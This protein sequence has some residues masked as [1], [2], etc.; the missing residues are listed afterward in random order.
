MDRNI[1]MRIA[2]L[3]A[4]LAAASAL[5]ACSA[6]ANTNDARDAAQ[7]SGGTADARTY[8]LA[9]FTGVSLMGSDNVVVQQ[10]GRFAVSASGDPAALD[11]LYLRVR[12][13]KLE[14][15]RRSDGDLVRSKLTVRV[16]MPMLELASV[17]GSGMID[18]QQLGG[19]RARISVAGSGDV[20]VA[21]VA[22]DA[23]DISVAGSGGVHAA[24]RADN[25]RFSVAG[26][27]DV[28][29]PNLELTTSAVS[30]GGS[31]SVHARVTG[32]ASVNIAGSGNATLTGG[33]QCTV[34]SVGS[35][36]AN[37]S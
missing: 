17:A 25:G 30:I 9:G 15:R 23:I 3:V 19:E 20:R 22:A 37:C 7:P 31:G 16:T 18:A 28:D 12:D 1:Y 26:S 34:R 33:A 11:Q 5:G 27:G 13:G 21:T 4:A 14:V 36:T 8:A 29:A 35:G 6:L 2:Q 32:N 10:G 24:G